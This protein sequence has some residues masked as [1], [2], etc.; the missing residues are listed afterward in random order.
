MASSAKSMLNRATTKHFP[1][2]KDFVSGGIITLYVGR[3][4]KKIEIHKKLLAS[5]SP[6]LNK[7]VNNDMREGTEGIIRLPDEGEEALTLFTE[8]AYTGEYGHGGDTL[9]TNTGNHTEPKQDPWLSLH[10]HLQLYV[11]SDKFNIPVLKQ[12]AESKFHLQISCVKPTTNKDVSG[13][14]LVIGYAYDNLPSS[15]PILGFLAQYAS[16]NLELLRPT[17]RFNQLISARPELLKELLMNLKG[18]SPKPTAKA[19]RTR[20]THDGHTTITLSYRKRI[21]T[22]GDQDQANK[23]TRTM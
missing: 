13:I 14:V 15:D 11:F 23:R 2:Y 12:L 21:G 5:I 1:K 16:C 19:P 6:E 10:E 8:W 3:N 20:R 4:R 17:T 7:H 22:T 18:P 9:I